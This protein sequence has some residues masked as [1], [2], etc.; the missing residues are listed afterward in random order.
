M[1]GC[2]QSRSWELSACGQP[3]VYEYAQS[4]MQ[5]CDGGICWFLHLHRHVK[6]P[7]MQSAV[8]LTE[9]NREHTRKRAGTTQTGV[10]SSSFHHSNEEA[11]MGRLCHNA[12]G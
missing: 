4:E 1:G 5:I 8:P 2:V 10:E 9:E 6:N 7:K 11:R 3:C 12:R